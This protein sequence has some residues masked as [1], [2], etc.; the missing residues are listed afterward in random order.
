MFIAGKV[1]EEMK[2]EG[3]VEFVSEIPKTAS[4]KILR[5]KLREQW[6]TKTKSSETKTKT[7]SSESKTKSK[8]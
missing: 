1:S 6:D 4:G 5:R 3:G 7:K 2:L 8:S